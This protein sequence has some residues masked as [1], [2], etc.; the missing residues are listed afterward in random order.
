M[1]FFGTTDDRPHTETIKRDR[2]AIS[3]DQSDLL[4]ELSSRAKKVGYDMSI[5]IVD[6]KMRV[7]LDNK[8]A[9]IDSDD[10]ECGRIMD[11]PTGVDLAEDV[12]HFKS[13]YNATEEITSK[14]RAILNSN[15]PLTTE[16]VKS[17]EDEVSR[18]EASI[19]ALQKVFAELGTPEPSKEA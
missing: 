18:T 12:A 13:L 11:A 4:K 2:L 6:G 9:K 5:L 19:D 17:I 3:S 14:Q 7:T 1:A 10:Y 8:L 16:A 15:T